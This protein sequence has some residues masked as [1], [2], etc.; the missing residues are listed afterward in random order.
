[1]K[2]GNLKFLT[3][4]MLIGGAVLVIFSMTSG[5]T[6]QPLSGADLVAFGG[7][8]CYVGRCDDDEMRSD[9]DGTYTECRDFDETD[10]CMMKM[11]PFD[12]VRGCTDDGEPPSHCCWSYGPLDCYSWT[13]CMWEG[14]QCV[15]EMNCGTEEEDDENCIGPGERV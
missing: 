2:Y 7:S 12:G 13:T 8:A 5:T 9:C 14:D 1:M 10:C 4:A 11:F 15:K 3:A 6:V